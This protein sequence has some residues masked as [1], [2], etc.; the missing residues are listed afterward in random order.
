MTI[1]FPPP[2]TLLLAGLVTVVSCSLLGAPATV[3][4]GPASDPGP[5]TPQTQNGVTVSMPSGW[6]LAEP[7][8]EIVKFQAQRDGGSTQ[9]QVQCHSALTKLEDIQ[10]IMREATFAVMGNAELIR[11]PYSLKKSYTAPVFEGYR[12]S[13]TVEGQERPAAVLI[14]YNKA[15]MGCSYGVF[16][17]SMAEADP[18]TL[19]PEF[20][21]M[22]ESLD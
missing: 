2:R 6:D 8:A 18:R 15:D 10:N 20:V 14:G 11:G 13:I 12:G 21:A 16:L 17:F 5:L 3:Y 19:E 1:E 22:L 4:P 7:K 9:F